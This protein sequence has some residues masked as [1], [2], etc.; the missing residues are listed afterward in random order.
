VGTA[1]ITQPD[2]STTTQ[3]RAIGRLKIRG[4]QTNLTWKYKDYALYSNYTFTNPKNVEPT[5]SDGSLITDTQ[6]N[7]LQTRIGDIASHQIN[8]GVNA[9]YWNR[10][11]VNL[12]LNY[13]G[14]KKT[15][16]NTTVEANP[17]DEIG[18]YTTLNG[19]ITLENVLPNASLQII[20]NNILD[21]EYA[22]PG[23]RSAD[24]KILA[25]QFPQNRRNIMLRLLADF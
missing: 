12:R 24:G 3:N 2:G 10:L 11:N 4:L 23:A 13:V 20:A 9:I 18:A 21:K 19:A 8:L 5:D 1:Q 17:L 15:G 6:G 16:K 14:N 22:H 25:A 7:P